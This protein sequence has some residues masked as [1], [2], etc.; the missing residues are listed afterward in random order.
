[1]AVDRAS[2]LQGLK[3]ATPIIVAV[4]PFGAIVGLG[5]IEAGI[6]RLESVAMPYLVFAGASQLAAYR[7]IG[8]GSPVFVILATTGM[9]NLRFA[10]Y[11]AAL[12]RH[13]RDQ[14]RWL[15]LIFASVMTD[16]GAT[17]TLHRFAT[18]PPR[19][20]RDYYAGL[21]LPLW[22]AWTTAAVLGVVLGASVPPSW[23]LDF[24]VPLVFL[25]L[26]V[27]SLRD[28][29][30]ALAAAVGGVVA[31]ALAG[32]P[33]QLGMMIASLLGIASGVL[34]EGSSRR[35]AAGERR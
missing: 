25:A 5:A 32:L 16:Q 15:R 1:M 8:L 22:L 34:G 19:S 2:V 9:I 21:A 30:A 13:F 35:A 33:L 18:S 14:P 24:A 27:A 26:L 12:A 17:V 10:M 20:K 11:S 3:D 4:L 7:L 31:V 28:R 23:Q 6:P 29:P